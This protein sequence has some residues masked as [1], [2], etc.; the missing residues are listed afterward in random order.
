MLTHCPFAYPKRQL[1]PKR[2]MQWRLDWLGNYSKATTPLIDK[3]VSLEY[4][5][6]NETIIVGGQN[7]KRHLGKNIL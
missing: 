7:G 5:V 2:Y 4:T 6:Y 3:T 1:Q